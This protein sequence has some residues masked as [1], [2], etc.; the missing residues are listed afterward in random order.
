MGKKRDKRNGAGRRD[1]GDA[2]NGWGNGNPDAAS[3]PGLLG[4]L[5]S[6]EQF[7]L[8][9]A[10]GAAAAWVLSDAELRGRLLKAGMRLYAG[11]AGGFEEMKEQM[12]DLK[13]EVEVERHQ[14]E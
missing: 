2:G 5:G 14:G 4:S 11:V 8:G 12:A 3:R 13:A 10:V 9:A 1:D 6:T 7:L